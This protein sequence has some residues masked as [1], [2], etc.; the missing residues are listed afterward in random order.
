MT[1]GRGR[2]RHREPAS[3]TGEEVEERLSGARV[4]ASRN[5]R[6][7]AILQPVPR[8]RLSARRAVARDTGTILGGAL[9][10]ILA[11]RLLGGG[12][13]IDPASPTPAESGVVIDGGSLPPLP[14]LAPLA[15][16]G[17]VVNASV[18]FKATPTPIPIIT[19]PPPTP[20]ATPRPTPRPTA[21]PTKTPA[22]PP[23]PVA[24]F[25]CSSSVP[26]TIEF[27]DAS[28]GLID[29]WSWAFGDGTMSFQQNPTHVYSDTGPY[30]VTLTVTG[31]GG[32]DQW[33]RSCSAM[34][35]PAS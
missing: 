10:A 14:T 18:G 12:I 4:E 34:A 1:D 24:D 30:D 8:G 35:P 6:R 5:A 13:V 9:I 23:A 19:L 16:L 32:S 22:P 21:K 33:A 28:T 2:G 27:A 31:P 26:L 29:S 3:L 15:T 25:T 7:A 20:R 11:S 17:P